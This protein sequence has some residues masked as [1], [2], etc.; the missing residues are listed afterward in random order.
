MKGK[1]GTPGKRSGS[2]L[3][4]LGGKTNSSGVWQATEPLAWQDGERDPRVPE[5][6]GA[7]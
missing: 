6:F 7:S 4:G 5:S 1:E 3:G 2:Q